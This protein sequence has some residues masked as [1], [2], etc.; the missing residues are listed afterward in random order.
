MYWFQS[1]SKIKITL[2]A[3]SLQGVDTSVRLSAVYV[4]AL[5]RNADDFETIIINWDCSDSP[6]A[7][8]YC[9]DHH[10]YID[11]V[12]WVTTKV[13]IIITFMLIKQIG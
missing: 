10:F 12:E 9:Y 7:N 4:Y 8:T 11:K 13:K 6:A 2:Q 3:I 5:D 1:T